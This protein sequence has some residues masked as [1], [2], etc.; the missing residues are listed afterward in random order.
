MARITDKLVKSLAAPEE[1]NRIVYDDEISG[2]GVRITAAG[3]VAF[4]L[5][6]R[7]NGRERRYTIG[8][9]GVDQWTVVRA[10]KKAGE[11][12]R[13]VADGKDPLADRI[14]A[15]DAPTIDDLCARFEE[16]HLPKKRPATQRDYK[17]LIARII[18]PELGKMKVT[19]VA[20]TDVDR[21]HR[22]IGE[23]AP[24][25]ANR[26][27]SVL[28]KM[29][30]LAIKWQ[31]RENNP[32]RGL[33]RNQE[34]KRTR[35]LSAAEVD[36]L[37]VALAKHDD[38]Q[39]ANIIRLLLL[40]GA[41]RGEVQAARWEDFDLTAGV[42]TKPGATTKQRTEH[43]VPLSAPARLLLS[44]IAA[45]AAEDAEY[46]F[47][48]R[49]SAGFRVE[50]KDDWA[51]LCKAAKIKNARLHDLR[52]TFASLLASAGMSLPIIGALLGHTQAQTTQRYSHLLDDPLRAA[53]E[54]V[55]AAVFADEKS[56]AV[57]PLHRG[58]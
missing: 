40:T 18:R 56:A 48:G 30:N 3:S 41:R 23:R 6:Y 20:F 57:A 52:H 53:T 16:E 46:V 12:R 25:R 2:F 27:A 11:L 26:L 5:N 37:T 32:V 24:Y 49:G 4:I 28:S 31:W 21:L 22:K 54:R 50:L 33:E 38:Q 34:N 39:A 15:R 17:A 19:A 44:E 42:W 47:P 10:R 9:Y 51:A 14:E 7:V 45:K 13:L 1:G 35:Y 29:F 58:A 43:R 55:A 36:R 8:S